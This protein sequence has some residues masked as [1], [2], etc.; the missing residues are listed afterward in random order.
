MKIMKVLCVDVKTHMQVLVEDCSYNMACFFL[1]QNKLINP[2]NVKIKYDYKTDRYI[3][4]DNNTCFVYDEI[5][6]LLLGD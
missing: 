4:T 1:E 2:E 5:R 6:G 3:I